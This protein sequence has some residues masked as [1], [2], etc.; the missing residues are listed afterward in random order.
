[1]TDKNLY[2]S[3]EIVEEETAHGRIKRT[4]FVGSRCLWTET[5]DE[6]DEFYYETL[7]K[8]IIDHKDDKY[9]PFCGLLIVV[10]EHDE[11]SD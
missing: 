4:L 11:Q 8:N 5:F 3:G 7:C 2:I 9:C 6:F 1:M 10:D